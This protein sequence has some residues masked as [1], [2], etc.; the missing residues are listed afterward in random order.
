MSEF[1][2]IEQCFRCGFNIRDTCTTKGVLLYGVEDVLRYGP[3]FCPEKYIIDIG[4][5][6]EDNIVGQ[7]I[8]TCSADCAV[9]SLSYIFDNNHEQFTLHYIM[10]SGAYDIQLPCLDTKIQKKYKLD[11]SKQTINN[12]PKKLERWGGKM[13]YEEYREHFICPI[14]IDA[15]KLK[16]EPIEQPVETLA[17]ND[18][19]SVLTI[20][21]S[22]SE[23]E[24]G[25]SVD[26]IS[27]LKD[28]DDDNDD[29][30]P[31]LEGSDSDESSDSGESSSESGESDSGNIDIE[32]GVVPDDDDIATDPIHN[33]IENTDYVEVDDPEAE[34]GDF[35]FIPDDMKK[36]FETPIKT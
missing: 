6:D 21:E 13:K 5:I 26:A 4:D 31:A 7:P 32:H 36:H 20:L 34:D 33:Y 16:T 22:D 8:M 12:D 10:L 1:N 15:D 28:Q 27:L 30:I 2:P 25:E 14:H 9:D 29:K 35:D 18:P 23:S 24:D 17:M 19:T 3:G 11:P